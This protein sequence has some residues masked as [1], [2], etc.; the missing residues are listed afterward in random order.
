MSKQDFKII[1]KPIPKLPWWINYVLIVLSALL[2]FVLIVYSIIG[3]Q[4]GVLEQDK[5]RINKQI[6]DIRA[7]GVAKIEKEL[8]ITVR[9]IDD[10]KIILS[11]HRITSR[12]FDFF[13]E[14]AH[15]QVQFSDFTLNG[16]DNR[17]T[18][19]AITESFKTLGE[20][21]LILQSREEI[22][23][24]QLSNIFLGKDGKVEF[25]ISFFLPEIFFK[26]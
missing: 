16:E 15:S 4:T 12:V 5:E 1:P 8:S 17:I 26:L 24:L 3:N 7:L 18:L 2:I 6:I 22:K 14:I 23:G 25:S 19:N 21:V 9:E 11:N 13:R 20:Q 10:F